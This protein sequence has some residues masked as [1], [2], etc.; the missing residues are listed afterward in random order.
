MEGAGSGSQKCDEKEWPVFKEK[1]QSINL[2]KAKEESL[3]RKRDKCVGSCQK[4]K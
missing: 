1:T 2:Q 3:S 4:V